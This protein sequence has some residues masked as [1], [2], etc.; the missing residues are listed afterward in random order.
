VTPG[1]RDPNLLIQKFKVII[2]PRG[3]MTRYE[4]LSRVYKLKDELKDRDGVTEDKY[5]AEEYLNKVL[6]FI[7][8]FTY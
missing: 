7:N 3:Q 5:L 2:M 6:D 4:I 8:E 1:K